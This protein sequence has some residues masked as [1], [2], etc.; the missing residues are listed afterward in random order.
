[1][2]VPLGDLL[3]PRLLALSRRQS[4]PVTLPSEYERVASVFIAHSLSLIESDISVAGCES[5]HSA[6][7]LLHT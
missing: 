7:P 6:E 1:M 5:Q 2:A 4:K 3:H